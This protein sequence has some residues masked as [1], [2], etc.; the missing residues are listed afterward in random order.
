MK[1]WKNI[2]KRGSSTVEAAL[3]MPMILTTLILVIY[4]SAYKHNQVVAEAICQEAV[5][6]GVEADRSHLNVLHAM[7]EML[8]KEKRYL[9]FA[10]S[11]STNARKNADI[12][13]A[14]IEVTMDLALPLLGSARLETI[15]KTVVGSCVHPVK[16][17]RTKGL[18]NAD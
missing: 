18:L 16:I 5:Y 8:E 17:M 11:I 10:N 6:A 2:E 13:T 14:E 9:F 4:L 1:K 12:I 7:N 15:R 3:L